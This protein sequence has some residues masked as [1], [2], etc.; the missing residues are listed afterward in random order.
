MSR[1]SRQN[2]PNRRYLRQRCDKLLAHE[3][4]SGPEGDGRVEPA[5]IS[6]RLPGSTKTQPVRKLEE[7]R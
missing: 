6:I 7:E 1:L 4:E 2:R 3:S 5:P